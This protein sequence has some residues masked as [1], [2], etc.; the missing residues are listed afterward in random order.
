[1]TTPSTL[2]PTKQPGF[3]SAILIACFSLVATFM[4]PIVGVVWAAMF[5]AVAWGIRRGQATAAVAGAGLCV[6][7]AVLYL[8]RTPLRQAPGDAIAG[9][10]LLVVMGSL[11]LRAAH[12][13]R[14][15]PAAVPAWPWI[16]FLCT[17]CAGQICFRT[18]SMSSASMIPTILVGD[19]FLVETI[20]WSAGRVPKRGEIVT[21][22]YPLDPQADS[23]KRVIGVP[24]DHI[25]FVDRQLMLSGKLVAEPY[26]IHTS[27]YP[28]RYRDNFPSGATDVPLQPRAR[29][30]IDSY[31]QNGEL[32]VPSGNVFVLGDNRDDSDDSR[33][34]GLVPRENIFGT[35]RLIYGS[36]DVPVSSAEQPVLPTVLNLRWSR[37]FGTL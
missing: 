28:D 31:A 22:H 20:T 7:P 24:G 30:M 5:F 11:L 8:L 14:R 26:A 25:R 10:L 13:L 15:M 3:R 34:W 23:V 18:Y 33:Y 35:P 36:Y 27:A 6:F 16:G 29:Q 12:R 17:V 4:S 37:L 2:K 21:F 9:V 1:M 32:V 19:Q